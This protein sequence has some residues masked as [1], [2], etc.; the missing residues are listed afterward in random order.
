MRDPDVDYRK[1][2]ITFFWLSWDDSMFLSL[3]FEIKLLC[4]QAILETTSE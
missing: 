2:V 4:F 3:E 1:K